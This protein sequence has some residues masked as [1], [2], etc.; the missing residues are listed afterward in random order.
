M[1]REASLFP[2][3]I[4]QSV[5]V[6]GRR[7]SCMT[8]FS[9]HTQPLPIVMQVLVYI[10]GASKCRW[11]TRIWFDMIYNIVKYHRRVPKNSR[12]NLLKDEVFTGLMGS[13][14]QVLICDFAHP[15]NSA[16]QGQTNEHALSKN[17]IITS[18]QRTNYPSPTLLTTF[19]T[20]YIAWIWGQLLFVDVIC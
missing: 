6:L 11:D 10:V 4:R 18:E 8:H 13:H 3:C 17:D 19:E 2:S 20:D 16:S 5:P 9:L 1:C 15:R 14:F 12:H 7:N